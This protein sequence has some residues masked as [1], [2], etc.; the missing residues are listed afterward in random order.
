MLLSKLY[1]EPKD[2]FPLVE[3]KNGVNFIFGKKDSK[4]DK[5][6]SLN[7]IGKSLLIDLIDFCFLSSTDKGKNPRLN[8]AFERMEGYSIILEF[9]QNDKNYLIKRAVDHPNKDIEFGEVGAT[10]LYKEK[11]L[12]EELCSFL[13]QRDYSGKFSTAWFR[14]L[15]PFFIKKEQPKQSFEFSDPIK[16]LAKTKESELNI[17]H[18]FLLGINNTLAY[19]NLDIQN[20]L[21][22][23]NPLM[24]G[25]ERFVQETYGLKD[26]SD[27]RNEVDKIRRSIEKAESDI[28]NFELA[29]KYGDTEQQLNELTAKIK[30]LLEE[31]HK[32]KQIVESYKESYRLSDEFDV[33]EVVEIYRQTN[34]L[35]AERI[36][37]TL[38]DAVNFRKQLSESRRRFLSHEIEALDKSITE[39]EKQI[40]I[41]DKD[42]GKFFGFLSAQNAISDLSEAYILISKEREKLNDIE[43]KVSLY[44]D[45]QKERADVRQEEGRLITEMI[46]FTEQI[47]KTHLKTFR[48]V[49]FELYNSA[50]VENQ[51]R[52]NFD[53]RVNE[54]TD[55][56][57]KINVSFP[58]DLSKGKN[59][60][61]TLIYDL[62]V[63]F[64]GIHQGL[65][66]PRFLIHDGIFDG[67]YKG[68]F[69][70][71]MEH[72]M[73]RSQKEKF[74]Y[75][76]TLNEEGE[77]SEKFGNTDKLNSEEISSL[78]II[79][80]TPSK[81]LFNQ[82]WD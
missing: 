55:S 51:N 7:G 74:Q 10:K 31:N 57:I 5:K 28:R 56:K 75:I 29:E 27:A 37:K 80:I 34:R 41:L 45:L 64:N 73:G 52:S 76:V 6:D 58:A 81:K 3:F 23:K 2:L 16:Y 43:G 67:M 35:L 69:L 79:N 78:A 33:N 47:Q 49:F 62:A 20:T 82:S 9:V 11:E 32:N 63:L 44:F 15:M 61:R 12:K 22:Q 36:E 24:S 21:E 71:L 26:I 13:F 4:S 25:V 59:R 65:K 53:I 77:L 42:R 60:G 68:H 66:M 40:Q 50:Y 14:R 39:N 38:E 17:Y 1:S 30:T 8:R 70:H 46:S 18:L 48:D 54:K 19:K 72:L